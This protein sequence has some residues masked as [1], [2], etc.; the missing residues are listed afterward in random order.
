VA[1]AA[2][3]A[4]ATQAQPITISTTLQHPD[5]Q[6]AT[7]ML[8]GFPLPQKVNLTKAVPVAARQPLHTL[9]DTTLLRTAFERIQSVPVQT[10]AIHVD[11]G[12]VTEQAATTPTSSLA[13]LN[14]NFN[15][16]EKLAFP[17]TTLG[18]IPLAMYVSGNDVRTAQVGGASGLG[19]LLWDLGTNDQDVVNV[20]GNVFVSNGQIA[21]VGVAGVA[22]EVFA[23][24]VILNDGTADAKP[25]LW[26]A[27]VTVTDSTDNRSKVYAVT[28]TGNVFRGP[29]QL[30]GRNLNPVPPAPMNTWHF[31]NSET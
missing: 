1:T 12:A 16:F 15:I 23:G 17:A 20:T 18:T 21:V 28:V 5:V 14:Q 30:P 25:S 7:S 19:F 4:A 3:F 22:R 29:A 26:L 31:F 6:F 10:S 27:P 9:Q 13:T 8:R 24:N 11:T 2:P